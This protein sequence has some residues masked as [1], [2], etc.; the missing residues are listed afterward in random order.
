MYPVPQRRFRSVCAGAATSSKPP[1]ATAS[2][3]PWSC[4]QTLR[5]PKPGSRRSRRAQSRRATMHRRRLPS[6]RWRSSSACA[7][8]IRARSAG[9]TVPAA[10]VLLGLAYPFAEWFSA[11]QPILDEIERMATESRTHSWSN[12]IRTARSHT[13]TEYLSCCAM[14]PSLSRKGVSGKSGAIQSSFPCIRGIRTELL[15]A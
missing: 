11:V 3:S 12:T 2:T 15:Q 10:G 8:L 5:A 4:R 7:S 6:L 9:D 14:T 1:E 13:S